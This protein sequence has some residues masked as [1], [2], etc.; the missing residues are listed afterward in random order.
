MRELTFIVAVTL[1]LFSGSVV[2]GM[3]LRCIEVFMREPAP[4]GGYAAVCT[5]GAV[6]FAAL[7]VALYSEYL[8][9]NR[10]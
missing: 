7:Y 8:E 1:G 5:I 4:V 3:L 10:K 6:G 9:R 2:G